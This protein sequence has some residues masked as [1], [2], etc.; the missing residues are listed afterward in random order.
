MIEPDFNKS[1]LLPAIIQ[2][3]TTNKVLML[4][5]MNL[6][7]YQMTKKEKIVHYFSRSKQRIWK[8]GESSGNI[9]KVKS[10]YL[11]CDQDT[12]L[13]KVEQ[14]GGA[15]CHKGYTSCFYR[16]IENDKVKIVEEQVFN[17]DD[18]YK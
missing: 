13:I 15:A 10:I 16:K 12:I 4:G 2:D 14:V 8:K 5:Y 18:V 3:E 1:E 11:D 9:Q 6:Q 7:A 17:P